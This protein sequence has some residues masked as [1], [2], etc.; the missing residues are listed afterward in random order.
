MS[1]KQYITLNGRKTEIKGDESNLLE[2]IR[3]NNI[4]IPTF[5]YHSDLSTYG[6][7]R[8]CVVDIEGQG[9]QTSC[10]IQPSDGMVVNTH[11]KDVRNIR[12]VALELLLA[13]H[14][15]SCPTC[16]KSDDCKLRSL[17]AQLGI[18]ESRFAEDEKN[19]ELD[20]SS[21]SL[22]RDPNK[23]VLC[24]DCV[25][26]C[27]EIQGVGALTFAHRGVDAQVMPAFGRNI[28]DVECVNCGQC[29]AV[30][31]TG[32]IHPK[33]EMQKVW[34][35][36]DDDEKVVVTQIAPAVRVAIGEM[37]GQQPGEISTGKLI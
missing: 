1:N 3:N 2:L 8:M 16:E 23:C 13:N 24:G 17:S 31:P 15:K 35:E 11:T 28:N 37:F 12:K 19:E 22:V 29:A 25:R 33:P 5:C 21:H 26:Y 27:E 10:S 4:D 7:C 36:I 34:S 6:A 14:D 9:V 18:A 32:A 30:C 20:R